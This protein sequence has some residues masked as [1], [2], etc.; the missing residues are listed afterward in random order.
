[1]N[2]VIC[3]SDR[4]DRNHFRAIKAESLSD[5]CKFVEECIRHDVLIWDDVNLCDES[6]LILVRFMKNGRICENV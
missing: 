4:L 5:A 2:F 6:G 3:C 1:M